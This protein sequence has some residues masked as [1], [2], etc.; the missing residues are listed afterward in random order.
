MPPATLP[1]RSA[2]SAWTAAVILLAAAAAVYL[3]AVG[4]GFV[5]DDFVWIA[6]SSVSPAGVRAAFGA[7]TGFFRPVVSLIFGANRLACGVDARCYGWVN[8]ALLTGCAAGV[9]LLA[10]A[11][12]RSAAAAV[13]AAAVWLFNWHGINMAVLWISGRTSL[14]LVLFATLGAAA[15]VRRR[16]L[17][18]A[19]LVFAAM[20]S[21]EEAML[22]PPILFGWMLFDSIRPQ[23]VDPARPGDKKDQRGR[24]AS[25]HPR[26]SSVSTP[27][28]SR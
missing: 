6:R 25:P 12:L 20:L 19:P 8:F 9:A 13:A 21:K 14:A 2:K 7:P 5:K 27:R 15:F 17:L 23:P 4:H 3:P 18:A 24:P 22:L 11:V 26:C 16:W 28:Y 10:H 1:P